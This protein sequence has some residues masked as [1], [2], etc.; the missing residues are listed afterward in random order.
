MCQK[1]SNNRTVFILITIVLII[2]NVVQFVLLLN[3]NKVNIISK[4]PSYVTSKTAMLR[5]EIEQHKSYK[6]YFNYGPINNRYQFKTNQ[7]TSRSNL[8]EFLIINLSPNESYSYQPI[9][10]DEYVGQWINFTT[11]NKP[12]LETSSPSKVTSN[13]AIMRG[14][15]TN[16][17]SN[18]LYYKFTYG[19]TLYPNQLS[20]V[21][22]LVA[23]FGN[24]TYTY[25]LTDLSPSTAY[26]YTI[27]AYEEYDEKMYNGGDWIF[28]T[29]PE[30]N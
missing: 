15:I 29:L 1:S 11:L 3:K 14:F 20:T 9:I 21:P 26:E 23:P 24:Y 25:N 5:F 2:L 18:H 27:L 13:Y 17:G 6:F 19:L 16:Y 7:L 12:I 4:Q 10:D 30:K 28:V 8:I 22:I